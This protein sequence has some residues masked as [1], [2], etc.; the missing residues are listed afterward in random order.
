[1]ATKPWFGFGWDQPK[2]IYNQFY[3]PEKLEEGTAIDLNDYFKI[4]MTL[5]LPTLA[6]F[7]SYVGLSLLRNWG[8]G[9]GSLAA[10]PAESKSNMLCKEWQSLPCRGGVIVLL[11]GFWL[12][13]GLFWVALAV[14]FWIL[15]E[16][17]RLDEGQV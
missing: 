5:G 4:G 11:I 10:V 16:L 7:V 17:A 13:Q 2:L 9:L 3:K 12:E 8:H 6:C 15:L 14:P 1:M